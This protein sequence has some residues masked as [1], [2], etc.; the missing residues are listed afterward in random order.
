[1]GLFL[2]AASHLISLVLISAD[3]NIESA[4]NGFFVG[5]IS[6][7]QFE[8]TDLNGWMTP[9]TAIQLCEEDKKCGGFTYKVTI[10]YQSSVE[11]CYT[12]QL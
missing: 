5:R 10:C 7:G 6:E 12:F 4:P 9:R 8:Y 3:V 2:L 1:M 11:I